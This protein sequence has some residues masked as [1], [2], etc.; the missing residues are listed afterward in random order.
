MIVK[1]RGVSYNQYFILNVYFKGCICLFICKFVREEISGRNKI[2]NVEKQ[3]T[4]QKN[5]NN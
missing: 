4:Q 2:P 5:E 3:I 1:S